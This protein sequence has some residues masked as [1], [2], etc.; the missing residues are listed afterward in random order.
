MKKIL[1]SDYDETFY[2]NDDDI[3]LNK[4]L[5]E[6]FRNN[7]NL[8]VIATGRSYYDLNVKVKKYKLSYDY[9]IFDHG[10]TIINNKNDV[11]LNVE[12]DNN[13]IF[14]LKNILLLEECQSYFC[15]S[16]F[17][18]RVDF[19]YGNLTKINVKY[20]SNKV[21]NMVMEKIIENFSEYVNVYYVS[22]RKIE[23]ISSSTSKVDAINKLIKTINIDKKNVYTIGDGYSDILMVK[24]FNGYCMK[25]SVPDIKEYAI[26]EV[27]SVSKLL[28][29]IID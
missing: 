26:E 5:V 17:E 12:I 29:K 22:D 27:D 7:G 9:A 14:D 18:S 2:I 3:E 20:K 28:E 6:K 11:L 23:I 16:K 21:A 24:E 15:C 13:I 4:K 1:V 19:D 25:E 8:F 10:A